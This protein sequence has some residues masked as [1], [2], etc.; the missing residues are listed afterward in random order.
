MHISSILSMSLET[1]RS[2]VLYW[3]SRFKPLTAWLESKNLV[4]VRV[5]GVAIF[6]TY[7]RSNHLIPYINALDRPIFIQL[8]QDA[9]RIVFSCFQS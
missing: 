1:L 9:L 5:R 3:M 7:S 8:L 2:G 4:S 6:C